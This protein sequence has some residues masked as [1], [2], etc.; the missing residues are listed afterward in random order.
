M[1]ALGTVL[2]WVGLLTAANAAE[3][4]WQ[5][6]DSAPTGSVAN[7]T[8]WTRAAWVGGITAR[9]DNINYSHSPSNILELPWNSVGSSAVYTNFNSTY[10]TNEHPVIR[11]SAKLVTINTNAYFQLGLRNSSSGAHL[12]FEGTNG[13]G[14][15]GFL[16]RDSV[17]I[18]LVNDRF[19]D[20]AFFYNRS[21]NHYRLDYD[22]TNRL[23]W[24]TN[25]ESGVRV[26]NFN[27]F[28]VSRPGGTASTTGSFLVD[29]VSVETFP[30]HVWAWWRCTLEPGA[31]FVE[32][33]GSFKLAFRAGVANADVPG[34][35]DPVW[36]GGG[37]VHNAGA[38]R[39]L[40]A[41]PAEAALPLPATTNWTFETAFRM[42]PAVGNTTFFD[43]STNL[44]HNAT[45]AWIQIGYST[46][47]Y[48]FANLRD[49]QQ[50]DS[51]YV[52]LGLRDFFP[53]GRWQHLAVV[54]SNANLTLYVDYQFVTNRVLTSPADGAYAFSAA[55]RATLGIALNGGNPAFADTSLDEIRFSAKALAP[56]EFLQPGQPMIVDIDNSPTNAPWQLTMKGILG[57]SYRVETSPSIGTNANWQYATNRVADYTFNYIDIPSTVP[58]TNFVR[59]LRTN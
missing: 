20:V 39:H 2:C 48:I 14:T 16:Y 53:N 59:I 18:P 12:A 15:F 54:K 41:G 29:D 32:Q 7:V 19:V 30:P 47:G 46:N 13:F 38:L 3:L 24:T 25:G 21:N 40:Q 1:K 23:A 33:L 42:S 34:S 56:A 17:F 28:V 43:W 9:V 31:R 26:T 27:Q 22:F 55:S 58:K 11:C 50:G 10:T 37:D 57:K 51:T 45:S 4:L 52:N 6:F 5:D 49:S 44:G 35:S 36:D 8:G